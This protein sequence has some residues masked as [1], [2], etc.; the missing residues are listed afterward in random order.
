MRRYLLDTGPA[1]HYLNRRGSVYERA[2]AASARGDRVGLAMPGLGELYAG[3]ELSAT[4]KENHKRLLRALG[5]LFVWPFDRAAAEEYGRLFAALRR[6][7][8]LMQQI[9][10]QIAA[11]ALTLGRCT[12]VTNDTDFSAIPGLAV[13]DWSA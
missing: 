10:I 13:E 5:S 8:R 3:I 7:G 4:R 1:G 2:E 12:V 9:D 11:I 6:K